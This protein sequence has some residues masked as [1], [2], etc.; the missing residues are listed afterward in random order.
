MNKKSYPIIKPWLYDTV[1]GIDYFTKDLMIDQNSKKLSPK[2]KEEIHKLGTDMKKAAL[3]NH[4]KEVKQYRNDDPTT[5]LTDP[6]QRGKLLE[7]GKL[8][9]DLAKNNINNPKFNKP[10]SRTGN[11]SGR[12]YWKEFAASGGKKLPE[13][14]PEDKGRM[15]ASD[16]WNKVIYPS[17]SIHEKGQWNAEKRKEK[18]QREKEEENENYARIGRVHN[19]TSMAKEVVS[20]VLDKIEIPRVKDFRRQP[21]LA[22]EPPLP[23]FERKNEGEIHEDCVREKLREGEILKQIEKELKHEV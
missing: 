12:D 20:D 9:D 7:I 3:D 4:S 23:K 21:E 1:E 22:F 5:H 11:P 19:S 6:K 16:M 18:L 14:S 15:S 13:V 2:E 17:M 10:R 8:E